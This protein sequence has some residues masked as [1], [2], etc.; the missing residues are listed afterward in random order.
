MFQPQ[1]MAI[2]WALQ[3]SYTYTAY[4]ASS[5]NLMK[6]MYILVSF[7]NQIGVKNAGPICN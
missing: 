5:Q 2:L 1:I 4:T 6:E 3:I 7:H